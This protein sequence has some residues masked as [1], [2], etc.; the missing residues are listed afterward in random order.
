[1]YQASI[2]SAMLTV[3]RL[4]LP[5]RFWLVEIIHNPWL[6]DG[7]WVTQSMGLV[8]CKRGSVG[9]RFAK[10]G[11]YEVQPLICMVGEEAV[12]HRRFS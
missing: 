2:P 5:E 4:S 1:V 10:G 11:L 9:I 8:A 6:F 12:P 3:G 7:K